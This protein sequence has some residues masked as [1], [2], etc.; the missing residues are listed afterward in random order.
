MDRVE[1]SIENHGN[2]RASR[3]TPGNQ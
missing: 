3:T 2:D 1:R